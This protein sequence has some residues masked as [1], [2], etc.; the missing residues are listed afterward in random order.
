M[1]D[2]SKI[3]NLLDEAYVRVA[4][5]VAKEES[6][7]SDL[8]T[9]LKRNIDAWNFGGYGWTSPVN[10]LMT[11]A[12][13]KHVDAPQDVCLIWARNTEG[14]IPGGFS[15]RSMDEKFTVPL[16]NKYT[17]FN[18]F[19]SNNSGMQGSRALE[20]S[21]LREAGTRIERDSELGQ[22]VSFDIVLFQTLI[23]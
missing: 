5:A 10:L 1:V 20:K 18:Q 16:V 15:I 22:R 3:R 7:G 19:C 11:A 21:K 13:V 17:I 6:V 23:L 8:P 12:W 9:I 14:P 2:E 4:D